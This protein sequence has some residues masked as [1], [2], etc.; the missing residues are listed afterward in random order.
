MAMTACHHHHAHEGHAH[1][2]VLQL[3]AYSELFEV[4][5]EAEPFVAGAE[6][7]IVAHFTFL[8]SFKP[9]E[10]GTV[11]AS[12]VSKG[13]V[14]AQDTLTAP[15]KQGI[16]KLHLTPLREGQGVVLFRVRTSGT[17]DVLRST[18]RCGPPSDEQQ[19]R[20]VHQR[21]ELESP[22][23]YRF[24]PA[25]TDGQRHPDDGASAASAG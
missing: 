13:E 6:S 7:E 3:T 8:D 25:A 16:Y 1:D 18:C 4:Y 20:G 24:V 15:T 14:L 10:A 2:E 11:V 12:L 22:V 9:L 5:A 21:G 19:R 17:E 23:R